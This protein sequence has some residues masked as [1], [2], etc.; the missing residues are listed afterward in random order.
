MSADGKEG[1]SASDRLTGTITSDPS[2]LSPNRIDASQLGWARWSF[3]HCDSC[4][5]FW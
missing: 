4:S 3:V 5:Y 1:R 2:G